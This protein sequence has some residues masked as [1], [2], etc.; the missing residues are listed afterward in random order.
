MFKWILFIGSTLI[1]IATTF[2]FGY[3]VTRINSNMERLSTKLNETEG[4]LINHIFQVRDF[5][6]EETKGLGLSNT[7]AILEGM[8]KQDT[9]Q[10]KNISRDL[11][12]IKVQALIYLATAG[13]LDVGNELTQSWK[14]MSF[15]QQ[16]QEKVKYAGE[17]GEHF[18][19]LI[20]EKKELQNEKQKNSRLLSKISL[21]GSI[22]Q[23][24]AL[25]MLGSS[26]IWF[27]L[28]G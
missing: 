27:K 2:V 26:E 15:E 25:L 12:I 28:S 10:Y 19:S 13:G 18:Q 20:L 14:N 23:V 9:P 5:Q 24:I 11:I 4:K 21:F 16:E 17:M 3:F 22:A 8:Q 6:I 1:I 7:L